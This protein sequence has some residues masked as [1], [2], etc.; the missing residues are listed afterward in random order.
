MFVRWNETEKECFALA[1]VELVGSFGWDG[2]RRK[3]A[4]V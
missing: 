1:V 3:L 4:C 2:H